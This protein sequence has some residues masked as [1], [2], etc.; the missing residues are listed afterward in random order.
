M[1]LPTEKIQVMDDI[2]HK[3]NATSNLQLPG[4]FGTEN[5]ETA[6]AVPLP[7]VYP[8]PL[9]PVDETSAHEDVVQKST[10]LTKTPAASGSVDGEIQHSS[11]G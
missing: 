10:N 5:V 8:M 2:S 3:Q 1:S 11:F 9:F 7:K 4:Y 6:F